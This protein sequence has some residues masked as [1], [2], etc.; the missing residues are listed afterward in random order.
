MAEII[1]QP[2]RKAIKKM[3]QVSQCVRALGLM[4]NPE[5]FALK[6]IGDLR[7]VAERIS[8]IS[9]RINDILDRYASI[10]AEFLFEAMD[11]VLDKINDIGD[12]ARFAIAET[13]SVLSSTLSSVDEMTNALG[14][15]VSTTTSAALQ[16]GGG[17]TYAATAMGAN[18]TLA[19]SGNSR[20]MIAQ[21]VAQD[22]NKGEVAIKDYDSE[23]KSRIDIASKGLES[24]SECIRDWTVNAAGKSTAATEDFFND[25]GSGISNASA[26]VND[27]ESKGTDFVDKYTGKAEEMA[28]KA[29][30]EIEQLIEKA[31]KVFDDLTK[32]FDEVF[33]GLLTGSGD[34]QPNEHLQY[35]LEQLGDSPMADAIGD[36][37]NAVADFIKNFDIVKVASAIGGIAVGAGAATLMMDMFPMVD[38]DRILKN[39][40]SGIDT[41]RIDKITQLYNNKH[42]DTEPDLLEVPDVPWRLSKDDL[43]KYTPDAYNKFLEDFSEENDRRRTEMLNRLQNSQ[44]RAERTEIRKENRELMRENKSALKAMRKIRRDAIK[45]KQIEKYKGF[46]KIE[47]DYLKRDCQNLKTSIKYEW[48]SMMQQYKDAIE[49]IR[50]FFTTEGSGGSEAID[51]CCD[52]INDD[53]EQIV[54]LCQSITVEITSCVTKVP[55]PYAIGSCF[56]MPVHKI[57][58][59]FQEI[60]IILTFVKNLIRLGIDIISQLTIIA[61]IIAGGLQSIAEVLELLKK[62]IGIDKIMKMIDFLIALF[63]P[64]MV[65]GKILIE[66]GLT[67]VYYNETEEFEAKVEQLEALLDDDEDGCKK[68]VVEKFKYTDDPYAKRKYRKLEYG[69][70]KAKDDEEIEEWLDELEAKGDR[71]IVAYRSPILNDAADDFAGWIF[72]HAD[73]YDNMKKSWRDTKKRR[74]NKLIK[75]AFKKN[76]IRNGKLIGGVSMLKSNKKFGHYEGN[77]YKKNTVTGY[78]AYFWYIQ[79]TNDPTDCVPDFSNVEK[80][81]DNDGILL[82]KKALQTEVVKPVTTTAN[83]SLIELDDGTRVFVEGQIVQSGDYVNVNGVRHRVK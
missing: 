54:E 10:P 24:A 78:D 82:Y 40:I 29:K 1:T 13:S 9:T 73:A 7:I 12:Y 8:S 60:K 75:K 79:W 31:R 19:M 65:E 39:V 67:P 33:G 44:T 37:G 61:K 56:D 11:S 6:V 47:L 48:D 36:V 17:L 74:R 38:V 26:W 15:A 25:I 30:M 45:A 28:N 46:L 80:V 3:A 16:I 14:S 20:T 42:Y 43:E 27:V 51:R 58:A 63:K 57:L 72:Y 21:D 69:G 83:G 49:E 64:K 70:G 76:K 77:S 18:I 32:N 5:D 59:F 4:P 50:K 68:G 81:Y 23:T 35:A 62:L 41:F 71:E 22:V 34:I 55:V 52:R 2:T 53:A 66:N